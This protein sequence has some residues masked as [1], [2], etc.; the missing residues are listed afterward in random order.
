VELP[1][2]VKDKLRQMVS[3]SKAQAVLFGQWGFDKQHGRAQGIAALFHGPPG[4]GKT[5]AA[6]VCPA[7]L[8]RPPS[9]PI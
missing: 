8:W 5:M 3:Y 1:A 7:R 9:S 6:E 2:S 4:T